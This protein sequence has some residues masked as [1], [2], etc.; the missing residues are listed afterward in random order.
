[1]LEDGIQMD[2]YPHVEAGLV[3]EEGHNME[4]GLLM[5]DDGQ[6]GDGLHMEDGHILEEG[7]IMDSAGQL[8]KE[9]SSRFYIEGTSR[10]LEDDQ[11]ADEIIHLD[12]DDGNVSLNNN[13]KQVG[14][15][16]PATDFRDLESNN[17]LET[18]PY[19]TPSDQW[20]PSLIQYDVTSGQSAWQTSEGPEPKTKIYSELTSE[21]QDIDNNLSEEL[22]NMIASHENELHHERNQQAKSTKYEIHTWDNI[23]DVLGA[24]HNQGT[25]AHVPKEYFPVEPSTTKDRK[26]FQLTKA[27]WQ[28]PALDVSKEV[29]RPLIGTW[30][31][32]QSATEKPQPVSVEA[33]GNYVEETIGNKVVFRSPPSAT[34]SQEVKYRPKWSPNLGQTALSSAPP[35][36]SPP[37]LRKIIRATKTPWAPPRS[38]G[39]SASQITLPA[40]SSRTNT[41]TLLQPTTVTTEVSLK[42]STS[43]PST[44]R[45]K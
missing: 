28:P 29:V 24:S 30:V 8:K 23:P 32:P 38:N 34:L 31:Q 44:E 10:I 7:I 39:T 19:S 20:P 43:L 12:G 11:T 2:Y 37:P 42:T 15:Y 1:L 33:A 45:S 16:Y 17:Y 14:N 18:G 35:P 27:I 6:L 40:S 22:I 26:E 13:N 9:P 21:H 36:L 41:A 3:M 25:S 4:S 5:E